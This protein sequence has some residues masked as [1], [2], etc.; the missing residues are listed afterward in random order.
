MTP[1]DLARLHEARRISPRA[2]SEAEFAGLTSGAGAGRVA[3]PQGFA[4]GRALAGEAELLTIA[5]LPGARRQGVGR[6]LVQKFLDE[7]AGLGAATVF[8]EVAEDNAGALALYRAAG[9]FEAGRRHRYYRMSDGT[10][11][12][13]LVMRCETGVVEPEI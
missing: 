13:A 2:W 7:V 12:D 1:A 3:E 6:R 9:F 10:L 11:T 4:L 8:L 5:V